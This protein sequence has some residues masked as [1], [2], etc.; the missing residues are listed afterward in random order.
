MKK[1]IR[2]CFL[3]LSKAFVLWLAFSTPVLAADDHP[4]SLSMQLLHL[5]KVCLVKLNDDLS[6]AIGEYQH[7]NSLMMGKLMSGDGVRAVTYMMI[8]LIIGC[9]A[10]W[11]YWTYAFGPMRAVKAIKAASPRHAL[12]IALRRFGISGFGL[13]LFGATTIGA[14]LGFTWPPGVDSIVVGATVFVLNL[15]FVWLI[16]DLVFS[17]RRENYRLVDIRPELI[18]GVT[19]LIMVITFLVAVDLFLPPLVDSVGQSKH[20]ANI[21]HFLCISL[22]ALILLI[23]TSA[24]MLASKD[25]GIAGLRGRTPSIPVAFFGVVGILIAYL[26]WIIEGETIASL[27]TIGIIAVA[28]EV[29]LHDLVFFFW[30]DKIEATKAD[31]NGPITDP[32]LAPRIILSGLRL[33]VILIGVGIGALIVR[34]SMN[35]LGTGQEWS[36]RLAL[37]IFGVAS[38]A[39]ITHS[40][41]T[42][43]TST[44]DHRL[45]VIGPVYPHVEGGP[46]ARL[47]TLLPLLRVTAAI[48]LGGMFTLTALWG[49]GIEITP[50]LAGA[51]VLGIA[52]GFGAQALVRD[53]I[54][55]IFLLIE[56][57]FRVGEY[58]ESGVNA[59]GTVERITLRTVALRHHNGPLHFVPFGS[60][61]AVRNNSRDWVIEKF[62]LPLK[63]DVDSE[64]V[65]KMIKKVG[66]SMLEDPDIG[67]L[68]MAPLKGKLYRVDPGIK[69][70]RCSFQTAPGRQYDVRAQAYKRIE[71]AMKDMGLTFA[72]GSQ[73]LLMTGG[74]PE[75][76][77]LGAAKAPNTEERPRS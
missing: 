18:R 5:A 44:I 15:R 11:L 26:L 14:S 39:F 34:S 43:I 8:L 75:P 71:A 16:C 69:I 21:L 46:N 63:L 68:I 31:K 60:L 58:I 66:E 48:G 29:G 17:P 30:N 23:A 41:W 37:R 7:L 38:L 13:L 45:H 49:L 20:L 27:A 9:S 10:E 4:S 77:T 53:V 64:K 73:T 50:L 12:R 76:D 1:L 6:G 3:Y 54:A 52:L 33:L 19:T 2:T 25:Q 65:R 57:V 40:I 62:N 56:D 24:P 72:Y 70:F 51:G 67:P 74:N 55:G 32:Q 59:K 47:L 42:V 35:D 36:L 28:I 22:I 61:G